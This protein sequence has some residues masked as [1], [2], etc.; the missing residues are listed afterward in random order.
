MSLS[1]NENTVVARV[2]S[3]KCVL[4]YLYQTVD[5]FLEFFFGH[6]F[7]IGGLNVIEAGES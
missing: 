6:V 3:L 2:E 5:K 7:C 4:F 1:S